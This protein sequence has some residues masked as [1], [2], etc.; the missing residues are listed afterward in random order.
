MDKLHPNKLSRF[1]IILIILLLVLI[2]AVFGYFVSPISPERVCTLIACRDSLELD[3]SQEPPTTYTVVVTSD[4]GETRSASCTLGESSA[5]SSDS[6]PNTTTCQPG[7]V[8]FYNFV[9]SPVTVEITWQGGSF[10]TSGRPN[11]HV[12]Q[13]N[14]PSCPPECQAGTFQVNIP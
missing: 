2:L 13:P 3:F 7:K 11:F 9:P 4:S 1:F 5:Q 12:F 6:L 10:S 8:T 14:G